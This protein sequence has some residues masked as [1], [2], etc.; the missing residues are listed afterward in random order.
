MWKEYCHKSWKSR[1]EQ[2]DFYSEFVS[3]LK[4][5]TLFLFYLSFW[6]V[7]TPV[8]ERRVIVFMWNG[9][10]LYRNMKTEGDVVKSKTPWN[11]CT[12][13]VSGREEKKRILM[14]KADLVPIGSGDKRDRQQ[15]MGRWFL[16]DFVFPFCSLF[17][18]ILFYS[19]IF[20]QV[21]PVASKFSILSQK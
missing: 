13:V 5:R 15:H 6:N 9:A 17:L 7:D 4:K 3:L 12:N 20:F 14:T 18:I 2:S 8:E 19:F 1:S 16:L 10:E 11:Q 21:L